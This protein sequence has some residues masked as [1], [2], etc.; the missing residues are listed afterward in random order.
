MLRIFERIEAWS[1]S[2][3]LGHAGELALLI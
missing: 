3:S 2:I 1:E